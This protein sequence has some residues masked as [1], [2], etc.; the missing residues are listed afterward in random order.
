[1]NLY[2]SP[3]LKSD[4]KGIPEEIQRKFYKQTEL[5]RQNLRHPSLRAKKYHEADDVWQARID[6]KY[7]LYFN[8]RLSTMRIS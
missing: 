2:H 8:S 5:L 4:I 3:R 1:M 7:R 6:R